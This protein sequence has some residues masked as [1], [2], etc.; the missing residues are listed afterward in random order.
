M[1]KNIF[2]YSAASAALGE[3]L[4]KLQQPDIQ[5]DEALRLYE[6]GLK[7]IEELEAHL[8]KAENTVK[9]LKLAAGKV[10]Q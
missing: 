2:D 1:A 8:Q 3:T 5:V 10:E 7:L 9:A 4:T 6:Q